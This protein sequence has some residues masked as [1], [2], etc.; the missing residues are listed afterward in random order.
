MV[1]LRHGAA[2]MQHGPHHLNHGLL[3]KSKLLREFSGDALALG[4]QLLHGRSG[5]AQ[6]A[7]SPP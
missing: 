3:R 2:A 1:E 7:Q 5:V 4:G 6:Q